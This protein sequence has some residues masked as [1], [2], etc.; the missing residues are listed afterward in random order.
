MTE[1]YRLLASMV[2]YASNRT[3][4][5]GIKNPTPKQLFA[6]PKIWFHDL[7]LN[8]MLDLKIL[9]FSAENQ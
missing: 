4:R 6:K 5:D 7:D 9:Y 8:S 3:V 1:P 2:Q